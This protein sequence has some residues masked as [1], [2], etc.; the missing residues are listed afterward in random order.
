MPRR[1]FEPPEGPDLFEYAH[2]RAT[3]PATSHEAAAS[4]PVTAQ[5]LR[6]LRAYQEHARPLLDHDAYRLVG[7]GGNRLCHQR[8]SDLRTKG[9]IE[10]T[11]DRAMTP[12]G[13]SGYVCVITPKGRAFLTGSA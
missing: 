3:D 7:L 5:A 10:R 9:L 4:V 12:S 11:G 2:A 1:R 8:C 6:V 13:K